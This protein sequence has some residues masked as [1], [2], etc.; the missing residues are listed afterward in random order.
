MDDDPPFVGKDDADAATEIGTSCP[1]AG[2]I[3]QVTP[4]KTGK[5]KATIFLQFC[6]ERLEGWKS[7]RVE[8][9]GE[10]RLAI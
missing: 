5:N 4:L 10:L 6:K 1:L 3:I 2:S 8:D 7:G 9:C